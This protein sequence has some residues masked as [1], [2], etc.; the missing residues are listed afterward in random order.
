[1]V[2][3]QYLS[4]NSLDEQWS[5]EVTVLFTFSRWGHWGSERWSEHPEIPPKSTW[6]SQDL[7]SRP[8]YSKVWLSVPHPAF[9]LVLW[10]K[11]ERILGGF[12]GTAVGWNWPSESA[13]LFPSPCG[14]RIVS[15]PLSFKFFHNIVIEALQPYFYLAHIYCVHIT[16]LHLPFKWVWGSLGTDWSNEKY[17]QVSNFVFQFYHWLRDSGQVV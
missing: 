13:Y 12:C 1:M 6:S 2:G 15:M 16:W 4:V 7:K 10:T 11:S 9:H 5:S 8:A 14:L 17:R 3:A